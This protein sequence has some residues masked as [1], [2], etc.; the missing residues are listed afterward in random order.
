MNKQDTYNSNLI[1][2]LLQGISPEE[3]E[4]TN[5]RMLLAARIDDAITKKGWKKKDLAKALD[6]TPSEISKW[7]S[8]THNFTIDTLFDIEKIL[9][10][11]LINIQEKQIES[12]IKLI[13]YVNGETSQKSLIDL[14]D[15]FSYGI[16]KPQFQKKYSYSTPD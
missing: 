3:L 12:T 7:L 9:D 11:D 4:R 2:E 8:G 6:K 13:A 16:Q 5:K 10:I 15:P 14:I 1:D